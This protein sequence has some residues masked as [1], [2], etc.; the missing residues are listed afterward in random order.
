[1]CDPRTAV[2]DAWPA[3][4]VLL[5][6]GAA[7]GALR[8]RA[9]GWRLDGDRVILRHRRIARQTL[10]ADRRRLQEHLTRQT[11]LQ[12]RRDLADLGVAVGSRHRARVRHLEAATARGLLAALRP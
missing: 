1:M 2:C 4:P 3:V 11:P 6:A 8:H 7:F 5:A 9:A 10:V 12:R